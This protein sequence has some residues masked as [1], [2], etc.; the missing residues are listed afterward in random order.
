MLSVATGLRFRLSQWLRGTKYP[1]NV[2]LTIVGILGPNGM[3]DLLVFRR[4]YLEEASRQL[5]PVCLIWVKV[6]SPPASLGVL[7]L[8]VSCL[9]Y[10]LTAN[11]HET[12]VLFAGWPTGG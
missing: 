10:R 4:D 11:R 5:G 7:A 12:S 9:F 8:Q 6:D 3:L 1:V 2:E